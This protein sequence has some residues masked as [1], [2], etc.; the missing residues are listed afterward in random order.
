MVI[1][2]KDIFYIWHLRLGHFGHQNIIC[3]THIS[4]TIYLSQPPIEDIYILCKEANMQVKPYR[5][6]IKLNKDP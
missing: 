5:N 6:M 2:N 4:K 3:F 1:I